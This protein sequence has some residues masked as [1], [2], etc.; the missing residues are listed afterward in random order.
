MKKKLLFIIWSN[1]YG[2]GAE[3]QLTNLVNH[4][5][6]DK[7]EID[8]LE[9]FHTDIKPEKLNSNI[10]ELRPIYN[11]V[12]DSKLKYKI[13]NYLVYKYPKILRW[14]YIKRKYD[15]EISFNY[16]I[17]T[18]LLS[19]DK[20]VKKIS[21]VHGAIWDIESKK[22]PWLYVLQQKSFKKVDRIVAI[23]TNTKESI[24]KL[25][26]EYK[27]KIEFIHNGYNF[28]MM[29]SLSKEK[30][31]I[32][33]NS[34]ITEFIFCNRFDD[35]KNPLLLIEACKLLIKETNKFHVSFI[36]SG[37]LK[38]TMVALICKYKLE[39]YI[40][41]L[42]YTS[43]PYPYIKNSDV[44]CLTSHSEGFSTLIIEGMHFKKP[45][46]STLGGISKEI[47]EENA[48]LIANTPLEFSIA[49]L[50]LIND[51][52]LYKELSNNGYIVSKKYSLTNQVKKTETL[53]DSLLE[54]NK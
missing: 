35:N 22:D 46:I 37:E 27:D 42:D 23:A 28:D 3:R 38:D 30:T 5:N 24:E 11:K 1:S 33:K 51:K 47:K 39:D 34:K 12:N 43:N 45:Y 36:G 10:R 20:N 17:P 52:K 53:I 31:D 50:K 40:S 54:E 41:V 13:V 6:N 7:Y 19:S 44:V 16:L 49:M 29:D 18:F 21:W 26:P 48:G 2:G 14:K 32:N 25:Y 9:Y 4:L 15:L 8:V